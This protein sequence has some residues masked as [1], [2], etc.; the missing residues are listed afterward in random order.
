MGLAG[1]DHG[2]GGKYLI[3]PPGYDG[4]IPD[5]Y[6]VAQSKTYSNWLVIRALDGVDSLLT[7]RIYPLAAVGRATRD[8]VPQLGVSF[9]GTHSNDFNFFEEINTIIQEE[10]V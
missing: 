9:N 8:G 7:T 3:L 5:G 6:F 10:P 2:K 4:E 1:R